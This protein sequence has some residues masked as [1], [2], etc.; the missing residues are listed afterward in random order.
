MKVFIFG[1]LLSL[2]LSLSITCFVP[3]NFIRLFGIPT[4]DVRERENHMRK[5]YAY[6]KKVEEFL[7]VERQHK[8][9]VSKMFNITPSGESA[10]PWGLSEWWENEFWNQ[11][12]EEEED[13]K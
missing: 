12:G 13:Y 6:E 8:L 11:E 5:K 9:F 10:I 4:Y 2:L 7:K 1:L 3:A